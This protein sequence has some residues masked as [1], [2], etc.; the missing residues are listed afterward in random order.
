MSSVYFLY[1]NQLSSIN[2]FSSIA[3]HTLIIGHTNLDNFILYSPFI[4]LYTSFIIYKFEPFI[5]N[6]KK[7]YKMI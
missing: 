6:I 5:N 4:I 2:I 1:Y 7:G 3:W